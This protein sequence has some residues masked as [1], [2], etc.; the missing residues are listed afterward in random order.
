[1]LS[2]RHRPF[3]SPQSKVVGF[4]LTVIFASTYG[5][6]LRTE[7]AIMV[8]SCPKS[9]ILAEKF[10][11]YKYLINKQLKNSFLYLRLWHAVRFIYCRASEKKNRRQVKK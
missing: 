2:S 5:R 10:G 9:K 11:I 4:L 8:F 7:A 6:Y 1:M 3:W